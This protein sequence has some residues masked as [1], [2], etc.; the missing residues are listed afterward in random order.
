MTSL[1]EIAISDST[2]L[3]IT[4][5]DLK[6]LLLQSIIFQERDKW[7]R[8]TMSVST[9]LRQ[10]HPVMFHTTQTETSC[11]VQDNSN[12]HIM[13]CSRQLRQKHPVQD[14]SDRRITFK[15]TQ[16]ETSCSKQLRQTH[17][18][19][20]K[21]TQTHSVMLMTQWLKVKGSTLLY[22]SFS[23]KCSVSLNQVTR[24]RLRKLLGH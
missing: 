8:N 12:R 14:N 23:H 24:S 13:S 11:H 4:E 16:T 9:Q 22:F 18:A 1:T 3:Y 6:H 7:C 15:T 5:V 2:V 20:F 17:N 10:K 21:T 19:M